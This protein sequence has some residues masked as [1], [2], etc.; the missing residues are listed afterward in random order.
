MNL[1]PEVNLL[2]L[3]QSEGDSKAFEHAGL[4]CLIIRH[5][6]C[7][8]LCGYVIIPDSSAL[9]SARG[10]YWGSDKLTELVGLNE[11]GEDPTPANLFDAHGGITWARRHSDRGHRFSIGFDCSHAGDLGPFTLQRPAFRWFLEG[12]ARKNDTYR[13]MEY[14]EEQTRSLADQIAAFIA[15]YEASA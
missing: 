1:A 13:T 9:T 12:D 11:D 15:K 3:V 10:E 14:V 8:H 7:G 2:G 6:E 5:P 4:D